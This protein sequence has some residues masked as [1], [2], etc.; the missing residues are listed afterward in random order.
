ME[1][2]KVKCVNKENE[3]FKLWSK[4]RKRQKKRI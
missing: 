4:V 3:R 1:G 2:D